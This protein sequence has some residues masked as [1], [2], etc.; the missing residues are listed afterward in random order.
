MNLV[1]ERGD[2]ETCSSACLKYRRYQSPFAALENENAAKVREVTLLKVKL[3]R[4][5]ET[6]TFIAVF[7]V[8]RSSRIFFV[9][10]VSL[11]SDLVL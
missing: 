11:I 1:H 9:P 3:L 2:F 6:A 10:A 5:F 4:H 8:C 7:E